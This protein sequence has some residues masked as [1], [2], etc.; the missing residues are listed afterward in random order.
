MALHACVA[1]AEP[2]AAFVRFVDS[3]EDSLSRSHGR[4]LRVSVSVVSLTPYTGT[5]LLLVVASP[6][7]PHVHVHVWA[8][9]S[10]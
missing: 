4:V 2:A 10:L 5:T 1:V 7:S 6:I 8:T 3:L 9:S